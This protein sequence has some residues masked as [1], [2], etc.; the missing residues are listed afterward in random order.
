MILPPEHHYPFVVPA[1]ATF[2]YLCLDNM[3]GMHARH[4]GKSSPL[5]EFLDHWFDAFNSGYLVFGLYYAA[6]QSHLSVL[7]ILAA[8]NLAYFATMWEQRHTG[9]IRFGRG[10]QVE[11][12]TVICFLYVAITLFGHEAICATP[13]FGLLSVVELSAVFL[14]LGYVVTV[15]GCAWRTRKVLPAFIEWLPLGLVTAGLLLWFHFGRMGFFPVA[16]LL[17]LTGSLFGGRHI[18]ARVLGK[19]YGALDPVLLGG[20]LVSGLASLGLNLDSDF[21]TGL[22]W[23]LAVYLLGRLSYDFVTTVHALRHHIRPGEF[24]ELVWRKR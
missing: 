3:H 7:I 8:T 10:G 19:T 24:L 17:L 15:A 20:I 16:F 5:G 1:V 9:V 13:I 6:R 18:I 4:T 22:G 2:L 21:Q 12:V 23:L 14:M 11:G